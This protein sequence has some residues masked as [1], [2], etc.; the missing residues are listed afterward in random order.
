MVD[1]NHDGIADKALTAEQVS[2]FG[3]NTV[4]ADFGISAD[5]NVTTAP[6]G[7]YLAANLG[8]SSCHDPHGQADGGTLNGALPISVSGSYGDQPADPTTSQAGNYRLLFDS[9]QVGFAN[10]APIARASGYDGKSTQYGSGM[11]GWCA[12][13]H[14]DFY[15]TTAATMHPTDI[16]VPLTYN[17]YVATGNFTGT[18]AAAYDPLVPFERGVTTGSWDLPDP[19]D[20]LTA[21]AGAVEGVSSVMCLSCHRAHASAFENALRWDPSAEFIAESWTEA[22]S[23]GVPVAAKP[24]YKHGVDL[25]VANAGT[26][27][28][29]TDGYGEFQRSLCNKCHVQD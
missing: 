27:N 25:D 9:N 13:C 11:S 14:G 23:S 22:P 15:A 5:A 1:S 20:P 18:A 16:S 12:N 7:T 2:N 28:P 26:G 21:G 29:F 3:H 17:N 10:D 4:A 19:T 24:Y 6:G 8:C